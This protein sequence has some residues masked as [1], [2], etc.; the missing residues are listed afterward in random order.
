MVGRTMVR[1]WA[2]FGAAGTLSLYLLVKVLWV[3][4]ALGSGRSL[5]EG[6]STGAWVALNTLTVGMAAV[7]IGLGLALACEWGMRLPA[8]PVLLFAW[9]AGGLL[10]ATVPFSLLGSLFSGGGGDGGASDDGGGSSW[11]LRLI[12]VGFTGMAVGVAVAL[13]IYLR[14]RWPD[15]LTGRVGALRAAR[16]P[17]A[18]MAATALI[19]ALDLY[20]A[21]GGGLGT[22]PD[23]RDGLEAAARSLLIGDASWALA[24][25]ASAWALAGHGRRLPL[26]LPVAVAF[27]ASGSLV[28][29]GLW[30]MPFAVLRPGDFEPYQLPLVSVAV[31]VLSVAAGVALAVHLGR[32]VRRRADQ[33]RA[34][35]K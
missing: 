17:Y 3:A 30:R 25:A 9:L 12:M 18:V 24:G 15:A 5:M 19:A 27:V 28:G 35:A 1:R 11:E 13:P 32:A 34:D 26:W 10:I 33:G 21:A 2:G 8:A 4:I 22:N 29:W 16:A 23:N 31:N 7:G 6:T 14:E 20:W